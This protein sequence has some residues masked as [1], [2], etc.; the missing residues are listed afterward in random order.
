FAIESA[1]MHEFPELSHGVVEILLTDHGG[2]IQV[3]KKSGDFSV[4]RAHV[5]VRRLAGAYHCYPRNL[6]CTSDLKPEELKG[7]FHLNRN[8][9]GQ[10]WAPNFSNR[11]HPYTRRIPLLALGNGLEIRLFKELQG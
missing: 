3:D 4:G 10:P 1:Q 9:T 8:E 6:S 5:A 2:P 7:R 11:T